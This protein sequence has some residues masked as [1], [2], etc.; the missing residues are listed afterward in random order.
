MTETLALHFICCVGCGW[1][2]TSTDTGGWSDQVIHPIAEA[3][4][5]VRVHLSTK[6]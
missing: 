2:V 5:L 6:K 1:S 3:V 4:V